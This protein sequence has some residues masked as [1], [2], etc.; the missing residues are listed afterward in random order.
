MQKKIG[1]KTSQ[2]ILPV[3]YMENRR[4]QNQPTFHADLLEAS[5]KWF[6]DVTDCP[7][8]NIMYCQACKQNWLYEN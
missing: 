2:N 6:Y 1:S 4:T 5:I 7:V 3:F 8:Q